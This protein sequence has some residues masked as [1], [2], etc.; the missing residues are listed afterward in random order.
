[1][2]TPRRENLHYRVLVVEDDFDARTAMV[3]ILEMYGYPTFGAANGKV[4]LEYLQS[5]RSPELIIL[6]LIM[7]VMD[8]WT[9][10]AEQM[11]NPKLAKIPVLVLSASHPQNIEVNHILIKPADVN[12][13]L[14]IVNRYVKTENRA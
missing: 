4:A 9:F 10:R 3:E 13:L 7:P 14:E 6:D 2:A 1:M 12:R 11:K 8:G 5:A